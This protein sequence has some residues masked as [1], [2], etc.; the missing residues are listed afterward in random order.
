VERKTTLRR[1]GDT[2]EANEMLDLELVSEAV[3]RNEEE[4]TAIVESQRERDLRESL[5][6][7]KWTEKK[8]KPPLLNH[9]EREI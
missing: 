8:K 1:D 5:E 7:V 4:E 2:E 9:R 3:D 6:R